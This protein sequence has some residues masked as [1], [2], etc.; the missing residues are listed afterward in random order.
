LR[1]VFFICRRNK[2]PL[3]TLPFNY[4]LCSML[5][6]VFLLLFGYFLFF[7]QT[8]G[9]HVLVDKNKLKVSSHRRIISNKLDNAIPESSGL[10]YFD[11]GLW[12]MNDGG[13]P[14]FLFKIDTSSGKILR[15]VFVIKALN[16]DWEALTQDDNWVYIGDFGN[17]F[18]SRRD[19]KILRIPKKELEKDTVMAEAIQ[20]SYSNQKDFRLPMNGHNF[21]CEAFCVAGDSLFLFTKNWVDHKTYVY[22]LSK[23]P[24]KYFV[25]PVDSFNSDG[26]ITDADYDEANRTLVLIGYDI[27]KFSVHSFLWVFKDFGGTRFFS[28]KKK[29]VKLHLFLKQTE[30]IAHDQRSNYFFTNEM[31]E[32]S[33]IH[34]RPKLYGLKLVLP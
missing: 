6:K 33:I 14:P 2:Q 21:D 8:F 1:R 27:K 28:G 3:F 7:D 31:I 25:S 12:T 5:K 34:I 29:R 10:I 11:R 26:L 4:Y 16:N 24:G 22:S 9:Q 30:A 19:L 13:N 23:L 20:F 18:G 32:K 15:R 17:N